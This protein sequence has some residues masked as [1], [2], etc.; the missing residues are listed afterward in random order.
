M[1][2]TTAYQ[3]VL[4]LDFICKKD[5]V[6]GRLFYLSMLQKNVIEVPI[7]R[8]LTFSECK[9]KIIEIFTLTL[10]TEYLS[11]HCDVI[12]LVTLKFYTLEAK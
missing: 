8:N 12:Q 7:L 6:C 10:G 9:I 1:L 4:C 5:F 11:F 3:N 2:K